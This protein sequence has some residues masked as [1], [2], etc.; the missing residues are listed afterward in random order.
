[1]KNKVSPNL[2]LIIGITWFFLILVGYSITH[3]VPTHE[4]LRLLL[5][6]AKTF[7]VVAIF[8]CLSG[9][10][11]QWITRKSINSALYFSVIQVLLGFGVISLW[12]LIFGSFFPINS[13]I[14]LVYLLC[15]TLVFSRNI[16][17]WMNSWL[18]KV[19]TLPM[20][21][22]FEAFLIIFLMAIFLIGFL[23]ANSPPIKYD[24]LMY[25]LTL[26]KAYLQNGG[27]TNLPWLVMSGMPQATE[28]LYLNV[29]ALAGE[30]AA[31][32]LN[33]MFGILS[34]IGLFSF[35]RHKVSRSAALV[36]VVSLFSGY[37]AISSL[38][39]GYVD[40]LGCLFGVGSIICLINY[41]SESNNADLMFS[42]LLSGLA[43]STKY[44]A[45]VL[46]LCGLITLFLYTWRT[47]QNIV[48][49]ILRYSSCAAIFAFPWLIKNFIFTGNPL[50]P[51]FFS[52]SAM[53]AT[54]LGVY[55]GAAPF[56]DLFDLFLL[57]VRAT[58]QGIDGTNGYSVSLG[59]LFLGLSIW[60]FLNQAEVD[61]DKKT[62]INLLGIFSLIGIIIWAIGNQVSGFLIQTRFY[63]SLFPA[64][65]MLSAF[66]F[67]QLLKSLMDKNIWIKLIQLAIGL[68]LFLVFTQISRDL[69]KNQTLQ[70]VF[71]LQSRQEYLEKN[72]GWYARAMNDINHL[73]GSEKV[74]FFYE[75]RGYECIQRCDPD[76]I[77]DQWKL[78]YHSGQTNDILL[79]NWRKLGFAYLLIYN[80]GM[81][82]LREYPDP[83]HPIIELNALD[84]LLSALKV[85]KEYGE[86]YSLYRIP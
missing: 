43:F 69:V 3:F 86:I 80:Q 85:E 19:T 79:A 42:G 62:T 75:P 28:L 18:K 70:Y 16:V 66:G 58:I 61:K 45:G 10:I 31:L 47:K 73:P 2:R 25:H 82:F 53:N 46:F 39:W 32:L 50:Y 6:N 34:A 64:F 11:G 30:S 52:S 26:P 55:Q 56:G 5:G 38:A 49:P 59:P 29:M 72:L 76:E 14:I 22:W 41:L 84:G 54:R 12:T 74:L 20:F 4:G 24:S 8:I 13:T 17:K 23:L 57:P 65:A 67:D 33:L 51:F 78:A 63:F 81:D 83:H 15:G 27:I 40:W 35:L 37:T 77:L 60:A 7:L 48:K 9:G 1:M 44:P 68:S 71:G 21:S 36:G